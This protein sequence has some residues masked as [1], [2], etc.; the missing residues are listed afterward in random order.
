MGNFTIEQQ[1]YI[2]DTI[3]LAVTQMELKVGAILGQGEAMQTRIQAIV[4]THNTELQ[5]SSGRVTA[6]V[7][8]VNAASAKL[9]GYTAIIDDADAKLKNAELFVADLVEKLRVFEGQF[10]SHTTEFTKLSSG[11]EA[12]VQGLEAK[13]SNGVSGTR[14]DA[15]AEFNAVNEKLGMMNMFCAGVKAEMQA[16]LA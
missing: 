5:D 7:E 8:Q 9:E 2:G 10:Q 6:L 14:A 15:Q 13:F 12:A 11:T 3:K 4:Q 16:M 1:A